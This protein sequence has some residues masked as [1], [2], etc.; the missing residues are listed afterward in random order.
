VPVFSTQ[1][2][3]A[4]RSFRK[5]W[6]T[7]VLRAHSIKPQWDKGRNKPLAR[8]SQAQFR[9]TDLHWHDLRHEAASRLVEWERRSET[10]V[11]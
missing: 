6:V 7:T 8:Q 1:D 5:A 2:G 9:E 11:L 10:S 4:I 3:G